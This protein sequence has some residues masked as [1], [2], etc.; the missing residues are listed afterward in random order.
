MIILQ[1]YAW[2]GDITWFYGHSEPRSI[3]FGSSEPKCGSFGS[4]SRNLTED[5]SVVTIW[6]YH[7]S[8][9][10]FPKIRNTRL[11]LKS[12]FLA[13]VCFNEIA[14]RLLGHGRLCSCASRALTCPPGRKKAA[15]SQQRQAAMVWLRMSYLHVNVTVGAAFLLWLY[16]WLE[17]K[18]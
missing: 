11:I 15:W 17:T 5:G 14:K 16:S 9:I 6:S 3:H 7:V 4:R 13:D 12:R 10:A 2:L 1:I 8:L 18:M